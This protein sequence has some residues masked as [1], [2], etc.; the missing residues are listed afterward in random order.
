MIVDKVIYENP[1]P[2]ITKPLAFKITFYSKITFH[3]IGENK[4][5]FSGHKNRFLIIIQ[6]LFWDSTSLR[7]NRAS[8]NATNLF[9]MKE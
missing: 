4:N 7:A 3:I 2:V 5:H 8:S 6:S 9:R 1:F